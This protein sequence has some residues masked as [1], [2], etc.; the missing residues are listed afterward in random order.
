MKLR[1]EQVDKK[2]TTHRVKIN[3]PETPEE[4]DQIVKELQAMPFK[5]K[6]PSRILKGDRWNHLRISLSKKEATL[7]SLLEMRDV[8]RDGWVSNSIK[9]TYCLWYLEG[10]LQTDMLYQ[11]S[12]SFSFQDKE[13]AEL[14]LSNFK[15]DLE[16]VKELIS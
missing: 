4:R 11:A 8:Y 10:V 14:F 16:Q 3:M 9:D 2:M 12:V 1:K 7:I 6:L 13:T 5:E 15:K